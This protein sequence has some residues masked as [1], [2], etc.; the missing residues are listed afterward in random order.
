MVRTGGL[1]TGR[2]ADGASR[3]GR[4]RCPRRGRVRASGVLALL[5]IA[6]CG[7]GCGDGDEEG[8]ESPPGRAALKQALSYAP[9][10][11]WG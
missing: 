11:F 4:P 9:P 7:A 3:D 2:M 8:G 1:R 10:K 6:L 5:L